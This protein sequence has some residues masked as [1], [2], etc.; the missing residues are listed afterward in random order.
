MATSCLKIMFPSV[1]YECMDQA[2]DSLPG[3]APD[4]NGALFHH[5]EAVC[6]VGLRCPPYNNYKELNC[7]VCSK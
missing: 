1:M 5:I 4:T 3:S 7:V 6:G 2:M